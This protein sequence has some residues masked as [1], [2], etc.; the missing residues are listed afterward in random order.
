MKKCVGLII[1]VESTSVLLPQSP[2][3]GWSCELLEA[4]SV[5]FSP[6]LTTLTSSVSDSDC[7][8]LERHQR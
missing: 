1:F 7:W 4:R 3:G 2:T 5:I 8:T 6:K